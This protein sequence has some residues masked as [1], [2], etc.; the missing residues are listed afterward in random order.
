[1]GTR[2]SGVLEDKEVERMKALR[3][4]VVGKKV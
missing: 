2:A 3:D 4:K 1:M